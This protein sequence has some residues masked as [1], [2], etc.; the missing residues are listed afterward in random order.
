[1]QKVEEIVGEWLDLPT[2]AERLDL[3]IT[4]VHA[5]INEGR[6]V[7]LRVGEPPVR[8]IPA[9]FLDGDAPLDA[10]HGTITLLR[11]S[12]FSDEELV[13]WLHTPDDSLPGTPMDALRSG[14]KTEV[15][16]RAQALAW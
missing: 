2:V 1:M 8:K 9:D 13:I 4:R 11:D 15:R 5:L 7:A 6:L 14:K 16:R 3:K 12:G 10:L